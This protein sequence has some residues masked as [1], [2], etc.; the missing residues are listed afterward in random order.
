MASTL[1][2]TEIAA[3]NATPEVSADSVGGPPY[4]IREVMDVEESTVS[5]LG[6][7]L[8]A[9]VT[10]DRVDGFDLSLTPRHLASA[11]LEV[12]QRSPAVLIRLSESVASE[13]ASEHNLDA[14]YQVF[15]GFPEVVFESGDA[16]FYNVAP[17]DDLAVAAVWRR[18]AKKALPRN[19]SIYERLRNQHR[20]VTAETAATLD[21]ID[22]ATR[23]LYTRLGTTNYIDSLTVPTTS[24]DG[25]HTAATGHPG[26]MLL[27]EPHPHSD[28][29][30][31]SRG[32]PSDAAL[33]IGHERYETDRF[34]AG[35]ESKVAIHSEPTHRAAM[36]SAPFEDSDAA[37]GRDGTYRQ[38]KPRFGRWYANLRG[39][40][41]LIDNI[42]SHEALEG[43]VGIRRQT[44]LRFQL[45]DGPSLADLLLQYR[46]TVPNSPLGELPALT[47]RKVTLRY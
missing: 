26:D 16:R 41:A 27:V 40:P 36:N 30:R 12:L 28:S 33:I 24:V 31:A 37:A 23:Q 43:P 11:A 14:Q 38:Y 15:V 35:P 20:P 22:T 39:L 29:V 2:T 4:D 10:T 7:R 6:E 13:I 45:A 32:T 19:V 8:A 34:G 9:L 17:L 5:A 21:R 42:A 46:D 47:N 3:S 25:V 44:E 1:P 18:L